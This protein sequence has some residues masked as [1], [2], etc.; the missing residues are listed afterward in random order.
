M[1]RM[2]RLCREMIGRLR[3]DG[4]SGAAGEGIGIV[5]ELTHKRR[6]GGRRG[7][8][9]LV[10]GRFFCFGCQRSHLPTN[11]D[12]SLITAG[13]LRWCLFRLGKAFAAVLWSRR[14]PRGQRLPGFRGPGLWWIASWTTTSVSRTAVCRS[15]F[16]CQQ[17]ILPGAR[18]DCQ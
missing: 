4:G 17:S 12:Y 2:C 16:G 18:A 5:C 11:F 13:W 8:S 7:G 15:A 3:G 1:C 14:L 9:G 6:R 10:N